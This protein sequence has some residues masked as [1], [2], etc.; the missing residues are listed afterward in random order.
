MSLLKWKEI[1]KRKTELG[2]NINFVHDAVLKNKL[3]EQVYRA[4]F[5]K[6]FKPITSK[7]DDVVLSNLKLPA[8]Q[9]KREKKMTVP[10]YGISTYDENV[11][12]YG[13]Y[14]LFDEEGIQP[15]I[16]KQLLP[17]GP[18]TYEETLGDK[19]KEGKQI[20]VDPQYLPSEPEDLSPEYDEDEVPDYALRE[21]DR[22][23]KILE[24]LDITDY[25]NVDKII[26]QP[27]MTPQKTRT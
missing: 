14:D 19:L 3:G 20:Y 5:Q 10:D 1:A 18:P 7:L 8:L 2:N 16:N 15:E 6:M 17:Y 9:R 25:D 24:D 27:E 13:L 4:S 12:D 23:N 22:I 26:R 11:P 21:E